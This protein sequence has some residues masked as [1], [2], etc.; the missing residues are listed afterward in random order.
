MA[1][2]AEGYGL[3]RKGMEWFWG[4]YLADPSEAANPLACP[5]RAADLRGLPPALVMTAEYDPLRDEGE[6]YGRALQAAGVPTEIV[7]W[8][9]M[10]HGFFFFVGVVDKSGA[11]MEQSCAWLLRTFAR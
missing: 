9:G 3:T 5:L 6:I 1:E 2:N 7:R 10:N 4:H 11:A 8:D